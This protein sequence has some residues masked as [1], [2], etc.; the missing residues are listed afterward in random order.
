MRIKIANLPIDWQDYCSNF[1]SG[2]ETQTD[3]K[4]V[5]SINFIDALPECHGI[6]YFDKAS[7]HVLRL[8]NGETLCA[9]ADWSEVTAYF[10]SQN[11][12]YA[13]L[14][15]A[16]CS[17]FSFYDVMLLHASCV[18]YNGEGILFTGFSGVGKTTQARLWEEYLKAQVINGDK[19]FVREINGSFYACGLP[20]KGSSEYCINKNVKLKGVVV[21]RQAKENRISK[22]DSVAA[23]EH[24][25]P[26][27]FL[28]HWDKACL[29]KTI[30]TFEKFLETTPVW[31][32]E[33]RPDEDAVQLTYKTLF[34]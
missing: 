3:E 31:L 34:D 9:N 33:C 22:L 26:H 32:L 20:W 13:L 8:E 4:A 15:A 14:L 23:M 2:F 5:M 1:V 21:L 24:F 7:E 30:D 6:Q 10:L 16:M 25:M 29:D 18:D 17:R 19:A 27:V 12:E 28:P 11:S